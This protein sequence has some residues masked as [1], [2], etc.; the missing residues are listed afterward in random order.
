MR[1]A[2]FDA[3]MKGLAVGLAHTACARQP[4]EGTRGLSDAVKRLAG[5]LGPLF[6][7]G[8]D[9]NDPV[10][11][12]RAALAVRLDDD[13][14]VGTAELLS[15]HGLEGKA[16]GEILA[17]VAAQFD[18]R[19]RVHEGRAAVWGGLLSGAL[20]GLKADLASGGLTMGGG[21]LAGGLLGALGGAGL[22]RGINVMR[23]GGPA[24]VGWNAEALQ[25][26]VDAALLRYLAVAHF[27]RGRGQW[28]EG[29]AP[30]HWREVVAQALVPHREPLLALWRSRIQ[31]F[32]AGA[33]EDRLAAALQPLLRAGAR[34]SL[35]RLYPGTWSARAA[36]ATL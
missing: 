28:S 27:G 35:E 32:E 9:P 24:W 31:Q 4:I 3:A 12:A 20:A 18:V 10:E 25:P 11:Q 7:G 6:G 23:G 33:D 16:Q 22:A 17:R 30:V 36:A 1:E 34:E 15:L 29:E 2:T 8:S 19:E 14:R 21:L 26:M 13:V 5:R